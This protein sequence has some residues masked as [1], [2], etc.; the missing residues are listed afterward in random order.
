MFALVNLPLS[1]HP[2]P[3]N[4]PIGNALRIVTEVMDNNWVSL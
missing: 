2:N 3:G 1:L 4:F